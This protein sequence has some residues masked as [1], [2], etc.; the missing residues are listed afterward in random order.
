MKKLC[1]LVNPS[2]G[3]GLAQ[4]EVYTVVERFYTQGW[5]TTVVPLAVEPDGMQMLGERIQ[6]FDMVVCCGG[7][8]TLNHA[9]NDFMGL[10]HPPV[11][12]Y[13]PMGTTNDFANTLRYSSGTAVNCQ[14]LHKGRTAGL[15]VGRFCGDKYFCYI[16]AFGAFTEVSYSTPQLM[17]NSLGHA[18]YVLEGIRHLPINTSIH[19]RVITDSETVE[20]DFIYGSLSNS[21]SIGGFPSPIGDQVVLDDGLFEMLLISAPKN[22]ADLNGLVASLAQHDFSNPYIR[23]VRTTRAQLEFEEAVSFTLDGEF[24]GAVRTAQLEVLPRAIQMRLPAQAPL[25]GPQTPAL[26]AETK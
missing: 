14:L 13:L 11:L 26:P 16:A 5:I 19:A 2:S 10:P 22:L 18:A 9:V 15:D 17:K 1:L 23:L 21:T 20:G 6:D 12:G 24:G 3:K 25:S 4:R 7:D 8:G